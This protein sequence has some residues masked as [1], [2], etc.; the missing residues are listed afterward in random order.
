MIVRSLIVVF[1]ARV[2]TG[3]VSMGKFSAEWVE[4]TGTW[5]GA[6]ATESK[7]GTR[8]SSRYTA[9]SVSQL[10]VPAW[11]PAWMGH[12]SPTGSQTQSPRRLTSHNADRNHPGARDDG[13]PWRARQARYIS[14]TASPLI[15]TP[16]SVCVIGDDAANGMGIS[17]LA[18][19]AMAHHRL[20]A[21][22]TGIGI[23]VRIS[24]HV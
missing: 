14:G 21:V 3:W 8:H 17:A 11:S 23:E 6:F 19:L 1:A 12:R 15:N 20:S 18:V 7:P 4:A 24:T 9:R 13:F 2:L 5:A 10:S 16:S 22:R